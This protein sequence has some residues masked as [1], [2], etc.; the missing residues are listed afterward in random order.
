MQACEL[1][2]VSSI[3]VAFPIHG[4]CFHVGQD[5][6]RGQPCSAGAFGVAARGL[7]GWLF[8]YRFGGRL[9]WLWRTVDRVGIPLRGTGSSERVNPQFC[10]NTI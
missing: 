1:S 9:R 10:V 8:G 6:L 5:F 2:S 4:V 7:L 3:A